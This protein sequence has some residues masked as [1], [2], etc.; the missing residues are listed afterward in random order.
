MFGSILAVLWYGGILVENN[1]ITIGELT[2]FVM[3][4]IT[5]ATG[6]VTAGGTLN[7][8][9]SAVAIAEKIF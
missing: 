1:E 8:I 7:D 6:I 3:Y 4:T 2:S 5:M 9:I